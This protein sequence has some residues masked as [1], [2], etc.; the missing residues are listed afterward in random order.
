MGMGLRRGRRGGRRRNRVGIGRRRR[1]TRF[2]RRRRGRGGL[3]LLLCCFGMRDP[4]Q[5]NQ[6]DIMELQQHQM[7]MLAIFQA[8]QAQGQMA[9]FPQGQGQMDFS[10]QAQGQ[11]GQFPPP[12]QT[13]FIVGAPQP[14]QQ[15]HLCTPQLSGFAPG[16]GNQD[17]MAQQ[18]R[19]LQEDQQNLLNE[20]LKQQAEEKDPQKLQELLQQQNE[21][22]QQ[23]Q[24]CQAAGFQYTSAV[25]VP[26][27]PHGGAPAA[28]SY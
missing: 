27:Q 12:G 14:Q 6:R 18:M 22:E 19:E 24:Q 15:Q 9:Q 16:P 28:A 8:Q 11:I 17:V 26:Q 1:R 5:Q 23:M 3:G 13:T 7:Q 2:G 25:P 21:I 4:Y 20:I 10:P